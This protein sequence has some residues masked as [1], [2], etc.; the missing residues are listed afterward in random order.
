MNRGSN[1]SNLQQT[2]RLKA[3]L[4]QQRPL[5]LQMMLQLLLLLPIHLV[6]LL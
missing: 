1:S 4:R 3:L 2:Q 5:L 6:P